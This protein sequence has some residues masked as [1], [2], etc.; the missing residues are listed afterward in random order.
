MHNKNLPN[1]YHFIDNLN[2]ENILNH[3]KNICLIYRNY[4]S[5]LNIQKLLNFKV[6]KNAI[7]ISISNEIDLAF[8]YR[9]DGI[10]LPSFYNKFKHNKFKNYKNFIIIGSAHSIKEIRIKEKQGVQQIFV[11]HCLKQQNNNYLG[12]MR[13]NNLSKST[14]K[15][16]IALGGINNNNIKQLKLVNSMGFA[17]ITYFN[18]NS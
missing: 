15:P 2:T 18:K 14:K 11:F 8:K 17:G 13:F 3:N 10:Y 6:C 1:I 7:E 5:K 4:N 16:L 9:L 12:I